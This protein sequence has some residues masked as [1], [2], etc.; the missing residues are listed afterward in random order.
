MIYTVNAILSLWL[1]VPAVI[2]WCRYKKTGPAYLPFLV[3]LSLG[4]VNEV[5]S[6]VTVRVYKTNMVNYNLFSLAEGALLLWQFYRWKVFGRR[7]LYLGLQAGLLLLWLWEGFVLHNLSVATSF[8]LIAY[9][10]VVVVLSIELLNRLIYFEP[11]GLYRNAR[12]LISLGLIIFF[13]YSVISET[14]WLYGLDDKPGLRLYV[15]TIRLVVNFFANLIFT[16]AVICI[17]LS[18]QYIMQS[19]FSAPS[20][21]V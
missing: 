19:L 4:F 16:V 6:L 2:G 3:L 11:F 8:H 21:E 17:P 13:V 14:F 7:W 15:L 12:Y 18:S 5:V 1:G 20:S 9:A 10:T